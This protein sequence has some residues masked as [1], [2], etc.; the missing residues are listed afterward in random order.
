V[1]IWLSAYAGQTDLRMATASFFIITALLVI[2]LFTFVSIQVKFGLMTDLHVA[3][4]D[5]RHFP[6]VLAI[7]LHLLA[8]AISV[9]FEAPT[10]LQLLLISMLSTTVLNAVINRWW[11]ISLH[12]AAF[13]RG[14]VVMTLLYGNRTLFLLLPLLLLVMW[15]RVYQQVHTYSQ[16]IFG[17]IV[18]ASVTY[19]VYRFS[20]LSV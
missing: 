4:R 2:P 3:I 15:S 10:A 19:T 1:T 18:A 12:A 8:I 6:Y 20:P 5:Q 7:V 9:E 13:A 11:K 14:S 16:V 17:A